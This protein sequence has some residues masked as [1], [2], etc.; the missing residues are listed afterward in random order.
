MEGKTSDRVPVPQLPLGENDQSL[1]ASINAFVHNYMSKYD[2]SHDY[3]HILR[4]LSNAHYIQTY[5]RVSNPSVKYDTTALYLAALLHDVGDHKYA[6]PGEDVE[7][8]IRDTLLAHGA[9]P[10]LADKVQTIVKHV[11][12]THEVRNPDAVKEMLLL[13][14][15]LGIV[16]DADRIDAI[17][18]VGIGRC[19]SFGAAKMPDQPM[20][21]AVTHFEEK[22]FKLVGMMKTGKGREMARERHAVLEGFAKQWKE[23]TRLAFKVE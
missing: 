13:H 17:G 20:E 10:E 16:Q 14:P 6:K 21:R 15:E 4:V 18:A 23:E 11:S 3:N 8:Q 9:N 7:N 1:F 19:F 2:N 5:E 22:L 12:Y